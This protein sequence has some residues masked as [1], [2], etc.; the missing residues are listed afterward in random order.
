MTGTGPATRGLLPAWPAIPSQVLC[1]DGGSLAGPENLCK[2]A[3]VTRF[4]ARAYG[5]AGLRKSHDLLPREHAKVGMGSIARAMV[6]VGVAARDAG[7]ATVTA[8]A[9]RRST[10][11][12]GANSPR[13]LTV[14]C[15]LVHGQ[16]PRRRGRRG[17]CSPREPGGFT[18]R[19]PGK[20]PEACD[21]PVHFGNTRRRKQRLLRAGTWAASARW[22]SG[23]AWLARGRQR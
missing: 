13:T 3:K 22:L 19:R 11:T 21:Q 12:S 7:A 14:H 6:T 23:E 5:I 15:L 16:A 18:R 20:H 17:L 4:G 1:R 9:P 8:F 10:P 2:P